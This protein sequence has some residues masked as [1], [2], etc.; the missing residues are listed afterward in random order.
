MRVSQAHK[1]RLVT[2]FGSFLS[3]KKKEMPRR[4]NG[5]LLNVLFSL[6]IPLSA[7][8]L[9]TVDTRHCV[10]TV[11]ISIT[12]TVWEK[13]QSN[14]LPRQFTAGWLKGITDFLEDI[15]LQG[16]FQLILM[17]SFVGVFRYK[18]HQ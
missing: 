4:G 3:L 8:R 2:R 18:I 16:L 12:S 10:S 7:L 5:R 9:S 17:S 1:K 13:G 15:P 6:L 14:L 11:I